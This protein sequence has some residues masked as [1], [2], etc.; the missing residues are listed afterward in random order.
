MYRYNLK[1][2]GASSAKYGNCEVCDKHASEVFYQTEER[3]YELP[4]FPA[5]YS[6][7]TGHGCFSYY[8]H[9]ECLKSQQRNE[10][11]VENA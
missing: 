8:G 1:S 3:T 11:E 5:N 7:W 9:E 6:G 2:T 10:L 4:T